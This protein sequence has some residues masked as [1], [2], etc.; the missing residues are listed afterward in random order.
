M[1]KNYDFRKAKRGAVIKPP[2]GKTRITI[3]I[4]DDVL[5][6]FRKQVHEAGG[7][8]YQATMN[9]ALREYMERDEEPLE[10]TLR[11]VL[12]EVLPGSDSKPRRAK[13]PAKARKKAGQ[14]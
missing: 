11:R 1:K 12:R 7:G 10:D 4:D 3:R 8:S 13:A 2:A 14:R 6:W 9:R 5:E